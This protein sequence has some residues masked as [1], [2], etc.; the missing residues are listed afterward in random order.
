[1]TARSPVLFQPGALPGN[2]PGQVVH[3]HVPLFTKQYSLVPGNYIGYGLSPQSVYVDRH[4][5]E[6]TDKFVYLG[7]TVDSTGYA[8]TD[9][10][11]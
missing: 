7:S 9:I 4:P 8:N 11:R 1:V 6:V 10:F 3:T 2:N 5:V